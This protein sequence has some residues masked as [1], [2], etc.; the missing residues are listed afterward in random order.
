LKLLRFN[1]D[2]VKIYEILFDIQNTHSLSKIKTKEYKQTEN[3]IIKLI[4]K[5]T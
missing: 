1:S 4:L 5:L 2:K 3:V